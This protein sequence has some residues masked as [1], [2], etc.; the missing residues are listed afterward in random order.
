MKNE[1]QKLKEKLDNLLME[2]SLEAQE[3]LDLSKEIDLLINEY[4]KQ[5]YYRQ[6][7]ANVTEYA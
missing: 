2:K 5:Y 1:L 3:V 4:Y 6:V 7:F